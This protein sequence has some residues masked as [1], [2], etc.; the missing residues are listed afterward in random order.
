MWVE[1]QIISKGNDTTT[2]KILR[3]N[4]LIEQWGFSNGLVVQRIYASDTVN[5][6]TNLHPLREREKRERV[7]TY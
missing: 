6:N 4:V 1:Q 7:P 3:S 5:A 2:R